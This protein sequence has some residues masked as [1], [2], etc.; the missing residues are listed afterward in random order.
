MATDT[1][2][3]TSLMNS[4]RRLSSSSAKRASGAAYYRIADGTLVLPREYLIILG[5]QKTH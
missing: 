3:I 2:W 4:R 1:R 5:H